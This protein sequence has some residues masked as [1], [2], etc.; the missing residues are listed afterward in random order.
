MKFAWVSLFGVAF[1][2]FYVL[3]VATGTI[4]DLRFF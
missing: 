2:D 3:L 1:A 4:S